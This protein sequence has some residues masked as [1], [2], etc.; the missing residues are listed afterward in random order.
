MSLSAFFIEA[1]ANTVRVLSCAAASEWTD[2]DRIVTATKNPAKRRIMPLRAWS[3]ARQRTQRRHW[4]SMKAIDGSAVPGVP[5]P[6]TADQDVAMA[7]LQHHR[8][9]AKALARSSFRSARVA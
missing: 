3:R 6:L 4:L 2:P 7:S 8:G 5:G 9:R 1:A